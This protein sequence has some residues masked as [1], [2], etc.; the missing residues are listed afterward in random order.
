MWDVIISPQLFMLLFRL[1]VAVRR[2]HSATHRPGIGTTELLLSLDPCG[3]RYLCSQSFTV[4]SLKNFNLA[5]VFLCSREERTNYRFDTET[6]FI[7]ASGTAHASS[8]SVDVL[9]SK[10]NR[11]F[12]QMKPT[13]GCQ[14]VITAPRPDWLTPAQRSSPGTHQVN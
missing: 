14:Q 1:N 8:A 13:T 2:R 12:L 6:W 10:I 9:T 11:I 7:S 4:W 5:S 3:R